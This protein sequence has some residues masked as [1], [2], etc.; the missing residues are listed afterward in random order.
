MRSGSSTPLTLASSSRRSHWSST[1]GG[2]QP[3]SCSVGCG[4]GTRARPGCWINTIPADGLVLQPEASAGCLCL[5]P[6]MCSVAL[7]P[8][9]DHYRWGIYSAK[10]SN[11]P[12]QQ[13][14][15][16]K[17]QYCMPYENDLPIFLCRGIKMPIEQTWPQ[18]K[19]FQ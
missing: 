14:A 12:V 15:V 2:P 11:T 19:F 6:I 4:S 3:R 1:A 17:C 16:N 10:G 7:E 18:T 9:P 8:R 13:V 5:F